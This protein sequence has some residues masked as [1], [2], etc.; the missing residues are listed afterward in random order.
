MID[1]LF[2]LYRDVARRFVLVVHPSMQAP[3]KAHCDAVVP[4][5]DIE[6]ACQ[7]QPTGMLDAI[8]LAGDAARAM[9]PERVWITWCDQVGVH[10][11]TI[12]ALQRLSSDQSQS[13]LVMPTARQEHPY[14]HLER[15]PDG[16]IH[17]VRQRREGDV[18]PAVGESD[19]GLFSLSHESYFDCL[20]RF[21]AVAGHA[22]A[23]RERNFLPFIAW[24]A[25]Q[26]HQI[27]TFPCTDEMEAIG[28]NTPDD[29]R[30]IE[31]YLRKRDRS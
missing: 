8:L 11:S 9:Q 14:I 30:R 12:A 6:Y 26:G 24:M 27:V 1:Y 19:I 15:S 16:R 22:A 7:G 4:H 3:V 18:M 25:G 17:A 13:H 31:Q 5:V 2:D 28:I 20:P 10:P 23:T 29:R 21:S